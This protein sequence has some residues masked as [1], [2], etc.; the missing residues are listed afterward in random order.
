MMSTRKKKKK[1][2]KNVFAWDLPNGPVVKNPPSNVGEMSS[3]PSQRTRIPRAT[4]QLSLSAYS[5]E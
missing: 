4:R 5:A 1:A 2:T 3:I